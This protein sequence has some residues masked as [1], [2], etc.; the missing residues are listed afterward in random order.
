M[1]AVIK[2]G[3]KQYRV[4]EGETIK[5][6][7]LQGEVGDTINLDKVLATGSG[8]SLTIGTPYLE[9]SNVQ[10]VIKEQG[11]GSKITIFKKKRRKGYQKKQGHRQLFTAL[12]INKIEVA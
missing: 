3:G 11:K 8:E 4:T 5:V 9:N 10:A 6:E 1:Y 7:F 2:T 12:S